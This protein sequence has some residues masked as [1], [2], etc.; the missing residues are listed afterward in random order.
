M[1]PA[2]LTRYSERRIFER[3]ELKGER[4]GEDV[5]EAVRG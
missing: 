5:E 2:V 4:E 1:G 3:R